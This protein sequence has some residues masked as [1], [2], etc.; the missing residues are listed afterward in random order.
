MGNK[1]YSQAA[2]DAQ[3]MLDNPRDS[4]VRVTINLDGD[5]LEEI[6]SM[7][8]KD[9][10][11]YQPWLNKFLRKVLFSEESFAN[12]IKQDLLLEL[13]SQYRLKKKTG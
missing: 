1:K 4:K 5:I 8:Q 13:E 10:D 2:I 3:K 7:A 6:K 9:G 12:K 11:K